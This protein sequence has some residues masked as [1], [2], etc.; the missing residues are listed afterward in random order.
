MKYNNK[1]RNIA[2]A[3]LAVL[4]FV[5]VA[6]VACQNKNDVQILAAVPEG[7]FSVGESFNVSM[8]LS[9]GSEPVL[10]V[11]KKYEALV[12]V[13]GTRVNVIGDP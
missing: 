12:K 4:V 9:D 5:S 8:V 10:S 11:D 7:P 13:E 3:L 2:L 6:L 1:S